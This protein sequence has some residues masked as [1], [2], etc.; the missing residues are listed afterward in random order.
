MAATLTTLS[1]LTRSQ[2]YQFAAS[3]AQTGPGSPITVAGSRQIAQASYSLGSGAGAA[4]QVM[5][6]TLSIAG[7][8]TTNLL[9]NA[10]TQLHCIDGT[11]TPTLTSIKFFCFELLSATQSDQD[12]NAGSA[13]TSIT[14]GAAGSN[15]WI[16]GPWGATDTYTLINGAKMHHEDEAGLAVAASKV[17]AVVNNDGAV[18]AKVMVTIF[19]VA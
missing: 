8:A 18:T 7:G 9:L 11:A 3:K 6:G 4:N 14:L 5:I 17:I 1:T 15:P 16:T 10:S 13:A 12:G 2:Q 19:G